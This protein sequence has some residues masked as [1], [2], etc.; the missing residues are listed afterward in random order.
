MRQRDKGTEMNS[1]SITIAISIIL[2]LVIFVGGAKTGEGVER[3]RIYNKCLV[4][5]ETQP[6]KT[7]VDLCKERMK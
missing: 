5:H 1:A 2:V 6:Y 7:A 4:E 3:A